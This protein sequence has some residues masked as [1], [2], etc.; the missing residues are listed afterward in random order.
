M[1]LAEFCWCKID[2]HGETDLCQ[3]ILKD[4]LTDG[5]V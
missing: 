3:N 1:G 5:K 2:Q 4:L